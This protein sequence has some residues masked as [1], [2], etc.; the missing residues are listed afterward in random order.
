M[1][2]ASG[3]PVLLRNEARAKLNLPPVP[4]G[5]E[6]ITPL[7]VTVGGKPSPQV[8]PIQDP[9]GPEQDGSYREEEPKALTNGHKQLEVSTVPRVKGDMASQQRYIDEVAG[10]LERFYA[11]Q[12]R[13][14]K[15]RKA[16]DRDKWDRELGDDLHGMVRS[17][18]E[19][20]G[21][22]YVARL[23]GD[24]F[25]MR[26]VEN[27]LKAMAEGTAE[28]LNRVTA[29]DIRDLGVDD[30]FKRARGE[31]AE[32]AAAAIGTRATVFAREEAAKQAPFPES[33]TKTWVANTDRHAS[34][35]GAT[36]ALDASFGGIEP[37]SE[38]GCKCTAVIN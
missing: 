35:N 38:P 18:V 19:R 4:E 25:D 37:G 27:Y 1:V 2:S 36:V 31:R 14:V 8:M 5:N 28:G 15:G 21:G 16:F 23:A 3:A 29:Q 20:E 24:D 30:A 13:Q 12:Y 26:Q 10:G 34:L 6:I 33:R 22:K 32:T 17:I 9:N 7:N 11:R